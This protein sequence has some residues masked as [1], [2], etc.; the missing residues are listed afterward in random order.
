MLLASSA[1]CV[2]GICC[3]FDV[4][5]VAYVLGLHSL[6]FIGFSLGCCVCRCMS[7]SSLSIVRLS[8]GM[9]YS[10]YL[11]HSSSALVADSSDMFSGSPFELAICCIVV[12]VMCCSVFV[13]S[14][15]WDS[16]SC[17]KLC[18]LLST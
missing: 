2:A 17:F 16:H 1:S 6:V 11:M 7:V 3:A 9:G 15:Y 5:F 13:M 18:M 12:H 4:S 10:L 8:V 14:L